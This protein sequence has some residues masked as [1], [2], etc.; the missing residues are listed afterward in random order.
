MG[1]NR[2]DEIR[3]EEI[4]KLATQKLLLTKLAKTQLACFGYITRTNSDKTVRKV[5]KSRKEGKG[6]RRRWKG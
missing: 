1:K 2:S 6:R 3:N 5:L 4:R